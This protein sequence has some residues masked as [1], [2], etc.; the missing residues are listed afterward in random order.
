ML[1]RDLARQAGNF[2]VSRPFWREK[3]IAWRMY[4]DGRFD[5]VDDLRLV[6][7]DFGQGR[8]GDRIA[9]NIGT[10]TAEYVLGVPEAGKEA[11][12]VKRNSGFLALLSRCATDTG[13]EPFETAAHGIR[14]ARPPDDMSARDMV[15]LVG[16]DGSMLCEQPQV[17]TFWH[18]LCSEEY[19]DAERSCICCGQRMRCVR[20][21]PTAVQAAGLKGTLVSSNSNCTNSH[22]HSQTSGSA[23]CLECA[24]ASAQTVNALLCSDEHH[25]RIG[26][27][28][29]VFWVDGD[30]SGT[31]AKAVKSADPADIRKGFALDDGD[32]AVDL[33][34]LL[35]GVYG[36]TPGADI[37]GRL[38]S[39][40]GLRQQGNGRISVVMEGAAPL[41]G[42]RRSIAEWF[43][44]QD[45]VCGEP[46]PMWRIHRAMCAWK[47]N[48]EL[49]RRIQRE[50]V[51]MAFLGKKPADWVMGA[52][53]SIMRRQAWKRQ[54]ICPEALALFELWRRRNN[55][56]EYKEALACGRLL[57]VMERAQYKYHGVAPN[58]S[59]ADTYIVDFARR[60]ARTLAKVWPKFQ[61]FVS[62]MGKD[63]RKAGVAYSLERDA[64][65]ILSG[66]PDGLP[67]AFVP[68]EQ[69]EFWRGY[70]AQRGMTRSMA[71]TQAQEQED[72]QNDQ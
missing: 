14:A 53:V 49:P 19:L 59:L 55:M 43:L 29:L 46:I 9:P 47:K 2:G 7:P 60:P 67:S 33:R 40:A 68:E 13:F 63:P 31:I 3:K 6:C 51:E 44:V 41:S 71:A 52:T 11:R 23:V 21:L 45:D 38:F 34:S 12:A 50:L 56:P 36:G 17:I 62:R 5:R 39:F 8:V 1:L 69:A 28:V 25:W 70:Q 57:A 48:A 54:P 18:K 10:D 24:L 72:E 16:V 26:D 4:P 64:Q 35:S 22:G 42:V 58:K 61:K 37:D 20:I 32:A 65:E 66:F 15:A 30:G 27:T